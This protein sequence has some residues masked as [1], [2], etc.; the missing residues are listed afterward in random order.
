[1]DQDT[2]DDLWAQIDRCRRIA[3]MMT[4]DE[5]RHALE[6]LAREY[7][8]ELFQCARRGFMLRR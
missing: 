8:E 6:E 3:S 7:E 1:M 5:I 2:T 4:D